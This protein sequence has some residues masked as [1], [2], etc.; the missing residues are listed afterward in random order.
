MRDFQIKFLSHSMHLRQL[1]LK[2]L[3]RKQ[4][5]HEPMKKKKNSELTNTNG[6]VQTNGGLGNELFGDTFINSYKNGAVQTSNQST[7]M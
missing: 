3:F 2:I 1:S 7:I 6:S 4:Y 5:Y